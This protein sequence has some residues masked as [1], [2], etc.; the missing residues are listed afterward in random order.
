MVQRF[1]VRN[2]AS[3]QLREETCPNGQVKLCRFGNVAE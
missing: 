3:A 1:H 2:V